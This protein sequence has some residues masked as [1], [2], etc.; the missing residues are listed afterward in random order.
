MP[1]PSWYDNPKILLT[2]VVLVLGGVFF[3]C[4]YCI[5]EAHSQ[6]TVT[7][8]L[9]PPGHD[10]QVQGVGRARYYLL[11]EY[12][13]LAKLDAEFVKMQVDFGDLSTMIEGLRKEMT[14]KDT[15]ITT[16]QADKKIL[17]DRGIRLEGNLKK[18]EDDLV[19]CSSSCMWPYIVGAVGVAFGLVGMGIWLGSR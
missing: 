10:G 2:I 1:S 6:T 14:A 12:L 4:C 13:Q 8:K 16:L 18:C 7:F 17:A 11:D 3:R 5:P 19:S 9:L 15:I